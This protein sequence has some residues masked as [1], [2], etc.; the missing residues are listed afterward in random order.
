MKR[1]P[2]CPLITQLTNFIPKINLCYDNPDL[3][4]YATPTIGVTIINLVQLKVAETIPASLVG[5]CPL[6]ET[7]VYYFTTKTLVVSCLNHLV[8]L[9]NVRSPA[10][11]SVISSFHCGEGALP[12]HL[13]YLGPS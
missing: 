7:M 9:L 6:S 8:Y 2:A 5:E 10:E 4:L 11:Y 3:A 1:N 12:N 13:Y